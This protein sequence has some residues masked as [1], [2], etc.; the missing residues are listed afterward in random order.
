MRKYLTNVW[1]CCAGLRPMFRLAD[2]LEDELVELIRLM[3]SNSQAG[4]GEGA[5]LEE[6]QTWSFL[7]LVSSWQRPKAPQV[8]TSVPATSDSDE[9]REGQAAARERMVE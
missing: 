1:F 4:A 2:E 7:K 6:S 5:D 9:K 3:P 8:G